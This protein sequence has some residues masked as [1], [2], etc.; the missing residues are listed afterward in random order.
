M[1]IKKPQTITYFDF[2]AHLQIT[3][4]KHS[5]LRSLGRKGLLI[6]CI[7]Y[8]CIHRHSWS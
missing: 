8:I 4:E 5:I 6:V 3:F 7:C 1:S 2:T